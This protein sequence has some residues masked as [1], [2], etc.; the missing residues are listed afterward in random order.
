MAT[1]KDSGIPGA[2]KE[3]E[4]LRQQP[5]SN[6]AITTQ[7]ETA[8]STSTKGCIA[9]G[10]FLKDLNWGE[11]GN[12]EQLPLKEVDFDL[13]LSLTEIIQKDGQEYI[14]LKFVPGDPENPFNWSGGRKAL[15]TLLLCLM[16][17]FIGLATTAYS[18]GIN[19]MVGDLGT[20]TELGQLGL[21]CF[22]MACAIAPLFIAPFCELVGRRVVYVRINLPLFGGS[23]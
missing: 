18:S 19:S 22:N 13:P 11:S 21:F 10:S 7:E 15:I 6:E 1:D 14:L 12:P 3:E 5:S 4:V 16:T 2:E 23:V 17:L 20:S 8:V 9:G